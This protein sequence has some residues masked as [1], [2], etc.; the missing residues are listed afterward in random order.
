VH[1]VQHKPRKNSVRERN[2]IGAKELECAEE[3]RTGLS[4]VPPDRVRCTRTVQY[5]TS[6][7]QEFGDALRYNSPDCL[8]CHRTVRCASGATAPYANGRL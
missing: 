7:S 3:W 4:G 8:V 6:H 1:K 2:F 5:S